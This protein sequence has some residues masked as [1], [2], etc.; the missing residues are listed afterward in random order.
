MIVSVVSMF[1]VHGPVVID[2]LLFDLVLQV[3]PEFFRSESMLVVGNICVV[4]RLLQSVSNVVPRG[5]MVG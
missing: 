3:L 5:G 1:F 4:R 2:R